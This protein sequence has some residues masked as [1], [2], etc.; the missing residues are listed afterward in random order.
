MLDFKLINTKIPEAAEEAASYRRREKEALPYLWKILSMVTEDWNSAASRLKERIFV[1]RSNHHW[2]G[3]T[4]TSEVVTAAFSSSAEALRILGVDG[5]QIY[6]DHKSP[7][8]WGYIQA[9][10]YEIGFGEKYRQA[11]FLTPSSLIFDGRIV[12]DEVVDM[13]RSIIEIQLASE[14][15]RQERDALIL[16]DG[17]LLPFAEKYGGEK[18]VQR[19]IDEY[20]AAL[21]RSHLIASYVS[22]PRSNLLNT[23]ACLALEVLVDNHVQTTVT[24]LEYANTVTDRQFM[25]YALNVGERSAIFQH[26]S[27]RNDTFIQVG[28]GIYFFFLRINHKEIVRVEIPEWIATDPQKVDAVHT[29]ILKDCKATG[30]SY[31]LSQAHNH[32]VINLDTT[33]TL[34]EKAERCYMQIAGELA[35]QSEKDRFKS[36]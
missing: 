24:S 22:S 9:V 25:L 7:V 4:P 30:Y 18:M 21:S 34:R 1:L 27:P 32:V 10:A 12:P 15:S 14:V 8:P 11:E 2:S 26:V 31:T 3:A 19:L 20:S 6:P 36:S 13:R 16:M 33:R 28:A 5:S 23:L 29:S 17:G 35:Q